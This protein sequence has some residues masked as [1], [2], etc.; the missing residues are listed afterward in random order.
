MCQSNS[1]AIPR[2]TKNLG[3]LFLLLLLSLCIIG[4]AEKTSVTEPNSAST[5]LLLP[6]VVDE[7]DCEIKF[8]YQ[9]GEHIL[10]EG[11]LSCVINK[12]S[13]VDSKTTELLDAGFLS[14][15]AAQFSEG[16]TDVDKAA[17]PYPQFVQPD[18][19]F[20]PGVYML[21]IDISV[22]NNNAKC[23]TL[24]DLDE[25]GNPLGLYDD[26]YIFRAD[27]LLFI[28]DTHEGDNGVLEF[29]N[30]NDVY[31]TVNARGIDYFDKKGFRAEH[32]YVFRLE[33]GETLSLQL[34]FVVTD[35]EAGGIH[36]LDSLY[37]TK[38]P[39]N[40]AAFVAK[41]HLPSRSEDIQ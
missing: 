31:T 41:I 39:G 38:V 18:G 19:S 21:L 30:G 2:A 17:L 37:L 27:G 10:K 11:Q 9:K 12:I 14:D 35:L 6:E 40:T 3:V 8:D 24:R 34:G 13:L 26:P 23:F 20:L 1:L 7:Q 29:Q 36:D 32:P 4:C 33:S 28:Q 22:T 25:L 5:I 15:A 16:N